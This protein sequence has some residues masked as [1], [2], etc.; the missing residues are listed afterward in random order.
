MRVSFLKKI[1]LMSLIYE[2]GFYFVGS[3]STENG[4]YSPK[5]DVRVSR[6]PI[7]IGAW[8]LYGFLLRRFYRYS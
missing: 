1:S 5:D 3:C 4:E 6:R 2:S 7:S 8:Q